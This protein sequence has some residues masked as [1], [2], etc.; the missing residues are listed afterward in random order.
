MSVLTWLKADKFAAAETA[1]AEKIKTRITVTHH[2][3]F[4]CKININIVIYD[5][6]TFQNDVIDQ[7]NHAIEYVNIRKRGNT[8]LIYEVSFPF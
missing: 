6:L 3:T 5:S 8:K 2:H 7:I 4:R 1:I